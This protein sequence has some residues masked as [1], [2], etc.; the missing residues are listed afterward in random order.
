MVTLGV[1]DQYGEPESYVLSL[2]R[3]TNSLS[4]LEPDMDSRTS[5]LETAWATKY[6][7]WSGFG[8]FLSVVTLSELV[9]GFFYTGSLKKD[10]LDSCTVFF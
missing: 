1:Q 5:K 4:S 6:F 8:S 3:V 2:I 10:F 7:P 9:A